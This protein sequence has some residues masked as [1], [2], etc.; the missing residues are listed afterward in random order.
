MLARWHR[1]QARAPGDSTPRALCE[2]CVTA[3]IL[4]RYG[5]LPKQG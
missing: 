3:V 5:T 4:C 1:T 2:V